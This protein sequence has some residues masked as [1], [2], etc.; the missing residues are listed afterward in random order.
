MLV[1]SFC[2]INFLLPVPTSDLV[3]VIFVNWAFIYWFSV[4]CDIN[5]LLPLPHS[6]FLGVIFVCFLSG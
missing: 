3:G 4:F 6:E 5:F 1:L 2:D